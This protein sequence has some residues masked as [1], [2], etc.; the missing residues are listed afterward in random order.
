MGKEIVG[1]EKVDYV[2]KKT[3]NPVV[4][5]TL[6]CV[7][8]QVSRERFEGREVDTIFISNKSP[9]YDQ[10]AAFPVGSRIT[11]QYNRWGSVESVVLDG[12]KG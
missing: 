8:D 12:K 2:S 6:H 9:M 3:N 10:C 4:G 11:V 5:L 1:K 7:S